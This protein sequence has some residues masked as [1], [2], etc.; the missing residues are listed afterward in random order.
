MLKILGRIF[1][2]YA[3]VVKVNVKPFLFTLVKRILWRVKKMCSLI[4]GERIG[5]V[6]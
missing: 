5:L 3:V 6:K 1:A 2:V 4:G